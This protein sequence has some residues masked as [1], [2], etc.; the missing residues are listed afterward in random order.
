MRKAELHLRE[1]RQ[2]REVGRDQTEGLCVN[3]RGGADTGVVCSIRDWQL[4][5]GLKPRKFLL[6]W[7]SVM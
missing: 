2:G 7:N 3:S 4:S 5:Q 1:P 6:S